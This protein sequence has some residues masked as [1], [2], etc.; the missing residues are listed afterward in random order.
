MKSIRGLF[1][2][3][4]AILLVTACSKQQVPTA[5]VL[6]AEAL[7]E[8][9]A[10]IEVDVDETPIF[11]AWEEPPRQT[12]RVMPKYPDEALQD[13][14]EGRVILNIVVDEKGV[15]LDA[16]VVT[17]NP[18]GVFDK[19]AIEAMKQ[20]V[21]EPAEQAGVPIKVRL[22]YPIQFTLAEKKR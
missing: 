22:A 14:T 10:T 8:S 2:I 16:S 1:L 4:G 18:P 21:F 12:K 20:W 19:A 15:V 17:A 9:V 6:E 13:G 7:D 11:L 5:T 3:A